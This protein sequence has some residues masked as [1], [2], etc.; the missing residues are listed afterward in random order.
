MHPQILRTGGDYRW[1]SEP[2]ALFQNSWKR[3]LF[4]QNK[5]DNDAKENRLH[6]LYDILTC[7]CRRKDDQN[8]YS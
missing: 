5:S 3:N 8:W 7:T 6:D 2:T 1:L 4:S